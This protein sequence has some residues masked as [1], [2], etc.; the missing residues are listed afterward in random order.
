MFARLRKAMEEREEGFTLIELLVVV[1]I[2]GI[3]AAIAIPVF[4]SQR[5]KGYDAQ[6]KS[7]VRNA[8][9]SEE[10]YLT[11]TNSYT[12][13]VANL[14]NS[15]FK[16]TANVELFGAVNGGQGYCLVSANKNSDKAFLWDSGQGGLVASNP[17]TGA[18]LA[19]AV[20]N[21]E[22]ACSASTVPT[23]TGA[24]IVS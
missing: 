20:S 11:D 21:A 5:K 8:A 9:T 1:I 4:L 19:T 18:D 12:T 14:N 13:T 17:Y 15:G 10:A 23:A 2:I 3:L 22:A 7:D 6:A 16:S 24:T